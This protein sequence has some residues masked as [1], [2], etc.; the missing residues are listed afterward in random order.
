MTNTPSRRIALFFNDLTPH[1]DRNTKSDTNPKVTY[2][3]RMAGEDGACG[4]SARP[5][6]LGYVPPAP[7]RIRVRVDRKAGEWTAP[8][9]VRG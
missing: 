7:R 3:S 1:S 9:R 2:F 5:T 6:I 4:T 8:R